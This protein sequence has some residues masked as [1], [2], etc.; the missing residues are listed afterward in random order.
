MSGLAAGTRL[1]STV[2]T[3]EIMIIAAP[4]GEV[5]LTCGGAPMTDGDGNQN[6]GSLHQD[7][8][9]GTT[10]GKR[11]ISEEGDLEILCVKPGEGSLAVAGTALKLKEA[12]KLP[13][14][15]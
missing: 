12:K 7:H 3:A 6:G 8:A 5:D 4:D 13:K 14:T 15:D 2:C 11:Y 9:A 10:L 1:K